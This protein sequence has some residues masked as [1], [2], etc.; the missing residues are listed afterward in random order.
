[1]KAVP[2]TSKK[3]NPIP[4]RGV[5]PNAAT[6]STATASTVARATLSSLPL[7]FASGVALGAF[8]VLCALL[9]FAPVFLSSFW[10][11]TYDYAAQSL[12]SGVTACACVLMALRPREESEFRRTPILLCVAAFFGWQILSAV[13]TVYLHD[14]L[15]EIARVGTCVAWF[16]IARAVLRDNLD[17]EKVRLYSGV[18]SLRL[19]CVLGAVLVGALWET[20]PPVWDFLRNRH[21]G[22]MGTF[23]NTNLF[24]NF[25]A[26]S[27]PLALALATQ[28][29]R[30]KNNLYA[31]ATVV[32]CLLL[33]LMIVLGVAAS[34]SKGGFFA[35]L[36][37]LVVFAIC[38]WRAQRQRITQWIR[39]HRV[40]VAIFAT[41]FLI[42]G[43]AVVSKTVLPRLQQAGGSQ[44]H[45]TVF[46]AYTWRATARMAN[47]RP[48][49]GWG[50][51]SFP[52]AYPRF[53]ETGFTRSAHHVW[54]QI[55]AENGWPAMLILLAA[56]GSAAR[57]SWR[58]LREKQWPIAAGALGGLS[59][60]VAHGF[61]DA[62]WGIISIA[63]LA[64]LLLAFVDVL[65]DE[66]APEKGEKYAAKTPK[67]QLRFEWLGAALLL[68]PAAFFAQ[69]ATSA[70]DLRR[71]A[72]NALKGGDASTALRLAGEAV[73]NDSPSARAQITLAFARELNAQ[74]A[75][76]AY[77][78][79]VALRPTSAQI[80]Q[81]WAEYRARRGEPSGAF[82][83]QAIA[84]D[85]NNIGIR[86]A[87]GENRLRD[88]D[89]GGWNDIEEIA[90]LKDAPYGKY[91]ATPEAV[92]LDYA[93]AFS[94]L[95]ER[96]LE[97]GKKPSARKY[98]D[99]AAEVLAQARV[100]FDQ[101]N[102]MAQEMAKTGTE[103][104]PPENP[105]ELE[106]QLNALREQ[107]K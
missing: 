92:D 46:R 86:W 13:T 15:L 81:Q 90:R 32:L 14:T 71:Q 64:L 57:K 65:P 44:I 107:I 94:R 84:L 55:A 99:R 74:D 6:S 67:S 3:K 105:D 12:F 47:A 98:I 27:L 56:C 33:A 82:W 36:I 60:F 37:G 89:A 104:A 11:T 96:D 34:V 19:I 83:D 9:V 95:A 10:P 20:A 77:Q 16:C 101:Q 85:R 21:L 35:T 106:S 50:A 39:A 87:R 5:T 8:V 79:A 52:S 7:G 53:A 1:M 45:S 102:A 100:H 66:N 42:G 22:Q 72:S 38:L 43:G 4:P 51:G 88:G 59:A 70:E 78:R 69:Q 31:R 28:C 2:R 93:R 18:L 103:M 26:L 91:P 80:R 97:R 23:Y 30:W 25:C 68:A 73:A 76:Q 58:A 41:L 40:S 75:E 62:G 49:L 63:L 17:N 29:A 48:L 24:A 61:I 54:L